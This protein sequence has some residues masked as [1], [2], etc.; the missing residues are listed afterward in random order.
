MDSLRSPKVAFGYHFYPDATHGLT[1]A[2]SLVDGLKFILEPISLT[3]LPVATLSRSSDS[4]SIVR[5]VMESEAKYREGARYF[6]LPERLPEPVLNQL[7]YNVLGELRKPSLAA[8]VFQRNVD[9]YPESTNVYDSLGDAYLAKG[10][11]A[12]AKASFQKSIDVAV[13]AKQAPQ[14]ETIEKLGQLERK[15]K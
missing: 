12:A 5:A 10:D 3:K 13:K 9:L 14:P 2:P 15:Q 1:P 4:A 7:G 8:W 11:T 6:G